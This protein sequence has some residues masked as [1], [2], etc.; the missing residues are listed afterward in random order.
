M[1]FLGSILILATLL[2]VAES[3]PYENYNSLNVSTYIEMNVYP[4]TNC[5]GTV[6]DDWEFDED[7]CYVKPQLGEYSFIT[8]DDVNMT[9]H[10]FWDCEGPTNTSFF[11]AST[12]YSMGSPLTPVT[13]EDAL[14][15][16]INLTWTTGGDGDWF[17][18]DVITHDG[19][20]AAMSPLMTHGESSWLN[21]TVTGAGDLS[22]LWKVSSE[23]CCDELYLYINDTDIDY[24]AGEI[25]WQYRVIGL[26]EGTHALGWFYYKDG[27][28]SIGFD[29]AF[30]DQVDFGV[31]A[32]VSLAEAL[33]NSELTWTTN[34]TEEAEWFGEPFISHD[35]VDAA[36]SGDIGYGES[37]FLSTEISG[38][39][40][41]SFWWKVSSE[42]EYDYLTFY[43]NETEVDY[44]TGEVDWEQKTFEIPDGDFIVEWVYNREYDDLLGQKSER[45]GEYEPANVA[46]VDQIV[47][48]PDIPSVSSQIVFSFFMICLMLAFLF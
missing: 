26:P 36:Q 21:T 41:F 15:D 31:V 22:F 16:N 24:I 18:E 42:E 10:E 34:D 12:C 13:L 14:N 43:I 33:D 45:F 19:V 46:F 3:A 38:P 17:G 32:P 4:T 48:T 35:G 7:Y 20:S 5:S 30:L 29:A 37:S 47:W 6:Y 1:K 28:V 25:D 8:G 44:I 40:T 9:W 23:S 27:S 39:G 2:L 11:A